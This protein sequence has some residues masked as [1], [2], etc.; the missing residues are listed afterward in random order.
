MKNLS[1][2]FTGYKKLIE[3]SNNRRAHL[4]FL[5]ILL[6]FNALIEVIS[7]SLVQPLTALASGEKILNLQEKSY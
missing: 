7:I 2:F 1:N 5:F 4:I 6:T 3:L